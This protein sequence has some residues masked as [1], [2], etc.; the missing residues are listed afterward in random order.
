MPKTVHVIAACSENLV[1]GRAVRLPWHIPEDH[2][3]FHTITAGHICILGR[4]SYET[5][6][7]AH[8]AG[9]Q[10]IVITRRAWPPAAANP[11]PSPLVAHSLAAAL[12][13]AESLPGEIYICGGARL[14]QESLG[15]IAAHPLRL[16]LTVV[17]AHVPGDTYFPAWQHLAWRELHRRES[18]DANFR[19][20][21][22]TLAPATQPEN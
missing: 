3:F 22:L 5:W 4:V 20:T 21:F 11:G 13:L 14:Y 2:A 7:Q 6:P 10:P 8:T 19:Y 18:A 1:I 15:L 12:A 16:H 9:R 17:H